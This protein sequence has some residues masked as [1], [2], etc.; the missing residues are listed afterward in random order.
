VIKSPSLKKKKK[1]KKKK[2]TMTS[3]H[4]EA[5]HTRR[6][7][8]NKDEPMLTIGPCLYDHKCTRNTSVIVVIIQHM[9]KKGAATAK[10]LERV[11]VS[12][13]VLLLS[14]R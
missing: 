14:F 6:R 13:Y 1:K 8:N 10:E 11:D 3:T 2:D 7:G 5:H 4:E 12:A 9:V